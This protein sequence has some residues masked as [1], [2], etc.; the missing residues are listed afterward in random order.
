VGRLLGL[1]LQRQ[2]RLAES[3]SEYKAAIQLEPD[4]P[5]PHFKL[6]TA[7]ALQERFTEAIPKLKEAARLA[8]GDLATRFNLGL[9]LTAQGKLQE[10]FSELQ[11]ALHLETD[12]ASTL[13][14]LGDNMRRQGRYAEALEWFRRGHELGSKRPDWPISAAQRLR[15]AEWLRE[16]ERLVQ[17]K[18]RLSG[19][20]RGEER[21]RDAAE[22][23]GFARICCTIRRFADS[24]RL[25]AEALAAEPKLAA[26]INARHRYNAACAAALAGTTQG[27]DEPP[28]DDVTRAHWRKQALDWLRADL[29]AWSKLVADNPPQAREIVIQS[30]QHWKG[31][32]DLTGLRD[33]AR[34]TKL[35]DDERK[36]WRALWS[37]VDALLAK[38]KPSSTP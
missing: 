37:E 10:G 4:L 23:L 24:A 32:P 13:M 5:E 12:N 35:P 34:V 3:I 1:I 31:D 27:Q 28:P 36:A 11:A 6:G 16:T 14:A 26:D 15:E 20:L 33:E 2:G 18:T 30:L 29:A 9:A 19:V 7:L 25:Y 22:Q 17:L 8:P 21:P 38:A